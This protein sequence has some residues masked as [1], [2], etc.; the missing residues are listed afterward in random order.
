MKALA[1]QKPVE[2]RNP[3]SSRPWMHVLDPLHGY[4]MLANK[5][6]QNGQAFAGG[7]NFGPLEHEV[8]TVGRMVEK[9]IELWGKGDWLDVSAPDVKP[10]MNT[11]KLNWDKAA[12]YL[13]WHPVYNW[14]Q[15]LAETVEW[16]KALESI[17][18]GNMRGVCVDQIERFSRKYHSIKKTEK[19]YS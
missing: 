12:N 3:G 4:L 14:E 11:L 7:W 5:L 13:K 15:A 10:E 17:H 9:A 2:V 19:A 6:M 18:T 16:F 8:I 1:R